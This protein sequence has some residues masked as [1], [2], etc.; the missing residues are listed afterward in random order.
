M[1][2]HI[3]ICIEDK[4]GPGPMI[5]DGEF[6]DTEFINRDVI[7]GELLKHVLDT[8]QDCEITNENLNHH[9][10]KGQTIVIKYWKEEGRKNI[11][12]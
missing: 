10:D 12:K 4:S 7:M 8:A 3:Q 11:C 5:Y 9:V 1:K 6:D 2:T